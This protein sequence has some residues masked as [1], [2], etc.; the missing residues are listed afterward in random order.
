MP[1]HF[2]G[3]GHKD[4][5]KDE[6]RDKDDIRADHVPSTSVPPPSVPHRQ[7][8]QSSTSSTNPPSILRRPDPS[9]HSDPSS[10][11]TSDY[12]Q[13][14]HTTTTGG[15]G[16]GSGSISSLSQRMSKGLSV[17]RSET[18]DSRTSTTSSNHHSSSTPPT[19]LSTDSLP[20]QNC[21]LPRSEA[22]ARFPF[23]TMTLSSTGTLSF[24]ALPVV[25]RP[26]VI[27]AVNRAWKKGSGISKITEIDYAPE[28]VRRAREEGRCDGGVWEVMMKDM[29]W[30]PTSADR[31]SYVSLGLLPPTSECCRFAGSRANTR[32]DQDG[33]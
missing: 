25:M 18:T 19:S 10:P 11:A 28:A 30:S 21:P 22:G 15:T 31:V 6:H 16:T 26:G 33:Y 9:V 3:L 23:F 27:D 17:N 24:I 32:V 29:P 20:D 1:I 7:S 2:P 12:G 4:K 13:T 5:H 14:A 8:T